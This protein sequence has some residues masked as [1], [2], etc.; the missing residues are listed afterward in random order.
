MV[1]CVP[2]ILL[3]GLYLIQYA[4][5]KSLWAIEPANNFTDIIR[6]AYPIGNGRLASTS[7]LYESYATQLI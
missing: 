2:N 1:L 4:Y 3:T 6:T 7:H 5:A